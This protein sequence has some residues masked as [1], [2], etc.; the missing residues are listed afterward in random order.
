MFEEDVFVLY[1]N[2][3]VINGHGPQTDRTRHH[4]SVEALNITHT[5]ED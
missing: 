4:M 2:R 5:Q 1:S 3:T